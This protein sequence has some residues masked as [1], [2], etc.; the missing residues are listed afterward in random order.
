VTPTLID[1]TGIPI[2]DPAHSPFD[3]ATFPPNP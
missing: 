2:H 3:P 1:V